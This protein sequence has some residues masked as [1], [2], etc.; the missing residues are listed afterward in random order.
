MRGLG[1]L[2]D[3]DLIEVYEKAIAINLEEDF[4]EMILVEM[5]KRGLRDIEVTTMH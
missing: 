4:T 3:F 5:N 1:I 2:T